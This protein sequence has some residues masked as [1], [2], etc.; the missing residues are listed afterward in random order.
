MAAAK[1][2]AEGVAAALAPTA[3]AMTGAGNGGG[4]QPL[5]NSKSYDQNLLYQE[6]STRSGSILVL[7][8]PINFYSYTCNN[9][10]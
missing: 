4:R 9:V 2:V 10:Y 3:L 6:I 1:M 7:S 5:K 8:I